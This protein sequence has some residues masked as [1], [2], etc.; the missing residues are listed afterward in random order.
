MKETLSEYLARGGAIVRCPPSDQA[1]RRAEPE[2]EGRR[3]LSLK[4]TP[5]LHKG[6]LRRTVGGES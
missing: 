2:M 5:E 1:P 6:K 4:R 3:A